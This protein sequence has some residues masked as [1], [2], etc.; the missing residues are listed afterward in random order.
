MKVHTSTFAS[1]NKDLIGRYFYITYDC[2]LFW[3]CDSYKSMCLLSGESEK[4]FFA[5]K[6][7]GRIKGNP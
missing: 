6:F 5:S 1:N 2:S 4:I 7:N 3:L